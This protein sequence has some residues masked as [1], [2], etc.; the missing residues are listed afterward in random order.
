MIWESLLR[1]QA[2]TDWTC[3]TVYGAA[4]F[5]VLHALAVSARPMPHSSLF[6]SRHLTCTHLLGRTLD[7]LTATVHVIVLVL[8][9]H[10]A[11][12]AL[13]PGGVD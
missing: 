4:A 8:L 11:G 2:F 1:V 9:G 7:A 10:T 3:I 5:A 13:L 12:T 6:I